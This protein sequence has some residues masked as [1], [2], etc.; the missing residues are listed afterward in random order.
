MATY[1]LLSVNGIYEDTEY[2]IEGFRF[3]SLDE[4]YMLKNSNLY[5][6]ADYMHESWIYGINENGVYIIYSGLENAK[7]IAGSMADYLKL[8]LIDDN[9][10]YPTLS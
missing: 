10:L 1:L 5:I 9:S 2:D 7:R 4:I 6:F 8:Y 3:Y